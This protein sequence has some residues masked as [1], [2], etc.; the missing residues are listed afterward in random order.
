MKESISI[1][2]FGP[3]K[4]VVI[5][6]V[7]PFTLFIGESASG[8]S[9][10]LKTLALFRYLY[11]IQQI[12]SFLAYAGLKKSPI[13]IRSAS[14]FES[15][16]FADF[17]D[18]KTE[19]VYSVKESNK[20][21]SV[22]YSKK[23]LAYSSNYLEKQD[24]SFHKIAVMPEMRNI[25]A[26]WADKGARLSGSYL[27]FYFHEGFGSFY[28]AI[29]KLEQ[30][31]KTLKLPLDGFSFEVK[32]SG[33][34]QKLVVKHA[35]GNDIELKKASSGV[36]TLTPLLSVLDYFANDFDFD[37]AFERSVITYLLRAKLNFEG[38]WSNLNIDKF[39]TRVQVM[40]EEPELSLYPDAQCELLNQM[41][42]IAYADKKEGRELYLSI[43]THSPY[44]LNQINVLMRRFKKEGV[45]LDCN[46]VAVYRV[47]DG[48]TT[49]LMATN[50]ITGEKVVNTMDLSETMNSIYEAYKQLI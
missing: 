17:V 15:S 37:A 31:K 34:R 16:G 20:V 30:S 4:D 1:K 22:L 33:S 32:K 39:P 45:G 23:G 27:N 38:N 11:K 19:I 28:D 7:K 43:A 9:T 44:I 6:D 42:Q 48:V 12:R 46:K 25:Y 8:K 47:N 24:L 13:R 50:N 26:A 3:L 41:V 10:I 2:N 35:N 40:V 18:D 14:Y 21:Y 36:Q 5:D 29:E 49:S